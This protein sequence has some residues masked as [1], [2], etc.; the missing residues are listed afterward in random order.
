MKVFFFLYLLG[1][2]RIRTRIQEAQKHTD[3]TDPD[4]QHW[5]GPWSMEGKTAHCSSAGG[6][7]AA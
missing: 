1:D 5:S 7:N 6:I 2:R 3:S 4:P